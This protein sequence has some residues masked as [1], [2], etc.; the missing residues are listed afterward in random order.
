MQ[1][2]LANVP[3]MVVGGKHEI[4]QVAEDQIF[5][6]YSYRFGFPY[7][8]SGSSSSTLFYSFNAGGIHFVALNPYVYYDKSCKH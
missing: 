1:P 7:Q 3:A 4:E 6:A 5:V 8:E 2:L